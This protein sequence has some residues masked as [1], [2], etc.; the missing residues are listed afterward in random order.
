MLTFNGRSE[1][2][3]KNTLIGIMKDINDVYQYMETD[4]D[5]NDTHR[6]NKNTH[7][8]S[9]NTT[10]NEILLKAHHRKRTKRIV[11]KHF[12]TEAHP[13]EKITNE[14]LQ[15]LLK[16][17]IISIDVNKERTKRK[18]K[19]EDETEPTEEYQHFNSSFIPSI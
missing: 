3:K 12:L 9:I 16:E 7:T 6:V 4:E 10:N 15:G 17:D 19:K 8:V 14:D 2:N 13:S 1:E 5:K 18:Q 11:N